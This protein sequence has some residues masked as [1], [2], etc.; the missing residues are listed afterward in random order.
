MISDHYV[1]CYYNKSLLTE[2]YYIIL[3]ANMVLK[4]VMLW[5]GQ[6]PIS[7]SIAV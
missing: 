7:G 1:M 2:S 4:G 5:S 6:Y 3:F